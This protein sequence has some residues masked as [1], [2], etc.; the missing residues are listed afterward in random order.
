M[1]MGLYD[2]FDCLIVIA[3]LLIV[4][5][6]VFV[7]GLYLDAGS[8]LMSHYH[9]GLVLHK[10]LV[11]NLGHRYSLIDYLLLTVM[12]L[13]ILFDPGMH[14]IDRTIKL[15]E[16]G[17]LLRRPVI[18]SGIASVPTTDTTGNEILALDQNT[19]IKFHQIQYLHKIHMIQ[20][21][22]QYLDGAA[23]VVLQPLVP[24]ISTQLGGKIEIQ[25]GFYQVRNAQKSRYLFLYDCGT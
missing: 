18:P 22:S 7:L 4:K 20:T 19:V 16:F 23:F 1:G 24:L 11:A 21:G 8:Y 2:V 17:I 9:L 12:Q 14:P 3:E 6:F 25:V 13:I 5:V 10:S 15:F